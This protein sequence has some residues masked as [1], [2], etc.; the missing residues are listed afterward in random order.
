MIIDNK[1][2]YLDLLF[3]HRRLKRLVAVELKLGEFQASDKGQLVIQN[4][5]GEPVAVSEEYITVSAK[6]CPAAVGGRIFFII[7]GHC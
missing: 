3:Y 2:Y 4:Y 5:P 6:K 1:D 7:P